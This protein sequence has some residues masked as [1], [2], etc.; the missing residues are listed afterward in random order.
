MPILFTIIRSGNDFSCKTDTD[1]SFF[2]GRRVPYENNIGL[3]NIFSGSRL[4]KLNYDSH[5]FTGA[6]GFWYG[7]PMLTT[8]I[9]P[10]G[11]C[12]AALRATM[13]PCE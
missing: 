1:P 3:Y 10:V 8:P 4:Q 11:F 12:I 13:A 5:D 9:T 6:F 2:V 7:S